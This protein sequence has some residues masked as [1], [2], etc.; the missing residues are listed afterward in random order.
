MLSSGWPNTSTEDQRDDV[1][2]V[3]LSI[4]NCFISY[5]FRILCLVLKLF[6]SCLYFLFKDRV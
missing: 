5:D 6:V 1:K 2:G 3:S 4:A